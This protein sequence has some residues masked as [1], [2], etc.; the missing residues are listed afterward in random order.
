MKLTVPNPAVFLVKKKPL[1]NTTVLFF[2]ISEEL[3]QFK[4]II[5]IKTDRY[6]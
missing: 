3:H 6:R 1:S 5:F 4:H 2:E